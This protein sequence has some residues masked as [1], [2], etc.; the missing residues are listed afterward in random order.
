MTE[1]DG[2]PV[3]MLDRTLRDCLATGSDPYQLRR[4]LNRAEIEGTVHPEI[5][6]TLRRNIETT[7]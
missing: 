7:D 6:R 5:A 3:T 2:L 1:V 4:A